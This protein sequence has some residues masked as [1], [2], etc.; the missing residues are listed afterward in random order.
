MGKGRVWSSF[1][2][3]GKALNRHEVALT[4]QN[5]A[6]LPMALP[7]TNATNELYLCLGGGTSD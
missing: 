3:M 2:A 5:P 1:L 6:P 4:H 7:S